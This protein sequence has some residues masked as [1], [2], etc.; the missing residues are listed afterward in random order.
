MGIVTLLVGVALIWLARYTFTQRQRQLAEARLKVTWPAVTGTITTNGLEEFEEESTNSD[1][2]TETS[3]RYA[4]R[5]AYQYEAH[6][7]MRTGMRIHVLEDPAYV[8]RGGAE[9]VCDRFPLGATVAVHVGPTPDDG[10]YLDGTI[11]EGREK[12][13]A[14]ALAVLLAGGGLVMVIVG[15]G[16]MVSGGE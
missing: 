15:I 16:M 10:A 1:G 5:I 2:S 3:T 14:I 13:M 6:G 12:A 7:Q 9:A 4:P 8:T 11:S